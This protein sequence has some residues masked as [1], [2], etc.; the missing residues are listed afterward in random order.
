[1]PERE[2]IFILNQK[3]QRHHSS[4]KGA[5]RKVHIKKFFINKL[6]TELGSFLVDTNQMLLLLKTQEEK[7]RTDEV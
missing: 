7:N 3:G 6:R 4:E 2:C 5:S 1:M